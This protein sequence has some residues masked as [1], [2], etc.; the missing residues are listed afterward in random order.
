MSAIRLGMAAAVLLA[1]IATAGC[2]TVYAGKYSFADGWREGEI[3]S[4]GIAASIATPQF[5]DCRQSLAQDKV[6]NSQ[7]ALV[8]FKYFGHNQRRVV[9]LAGEARAFRSGEQVYV[10]V[11][12]CALTLL[13]R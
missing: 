12:N 1:S 13:R 8:K 9:P 10:N 6:S 2:S 11:R 4:T 7:F 3:E 5:S